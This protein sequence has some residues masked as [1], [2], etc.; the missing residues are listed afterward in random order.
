MWGAWEEDMPFLIKGYLQWRHGT[1]PA[2][3]SEPMET[4]DSGHIFDVAVVSTF[5]M[6][7]SP[8]Q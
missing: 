2:Q 1:P 5:G 6:F 3:G 8:Q 4:G 7:V